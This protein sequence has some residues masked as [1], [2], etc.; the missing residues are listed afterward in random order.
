VA[1]CTWNRATELDHILATF[2]ELAVPPGLK[3]ELLVVN[4]NSTDDTDRVVGRYVGRLPIVPLFE[5][6]QGLSHACNL[7]VSRAAGDLI[8]FTDD[9]V[10]VDPGWLRAF[11]EAAARWP[12][13][14]YFAGPITLA[15]DVPPPRRL[16]PHLDWFCL[17]NLELGDV[18]RPL[19]RGQE[20]N[21]ANMA[22][23]RFVFESR[24]FDVDYG[25]VGH[26][27]LNG[28]E[29]LQIDQLQDHGLLGIYV[30][31][32]KIRHRVT[33]DRLTNRWAYG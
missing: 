22:F 16:V 15:F 30:P 8:V 17:G 33:A 10:L 29:T 32:A 20:F 14:A 5:P 21:G 7:A 13:A 23:H 9:D 4:N 24:H 31:G 11:V 26:E 19:A 3:W 6:R 28:E 27:R 12:S 25:V 2:C 18:E 1:L